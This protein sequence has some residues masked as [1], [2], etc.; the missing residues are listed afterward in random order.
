MALVSEVFNNTMIAHAFQLNLQIAEGRLSLNW[1]LHLLLFPF[2]TPRYLKL[3]V[4][5]RL[6]SERG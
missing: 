6:I 3:W 5:S 2:H 1:I 4:F